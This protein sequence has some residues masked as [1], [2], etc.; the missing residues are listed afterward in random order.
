MT[1]SLVFVNSSVHAFTTS[2]SLANIHAVLRD[3][4]QSPL[5]Q[6][7]RERAVERFA[8]ALYTFLAYD[9]ADQSNVA[10]LFPVTDNVRIEDVVELKDWEACGVSDVC[11]ITDGKPG[12]VCV[13][14]ISAD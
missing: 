6:E 4:A 3:I 10:E 11:W 8:S 12:D 14:R 7:T 2:A 9:T 1:S 5:P 13:F